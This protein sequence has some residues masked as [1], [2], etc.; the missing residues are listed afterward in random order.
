LDLCEIRPSE[1]A[2]QFEYLLAWIYD[3]NF[4]LPAASIINLALCLEIP[5]I[6]LFDIQGVGT[7]LYFRCRIGSSDGRFTISVPAE[8][9]LE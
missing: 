4:S 2:K 3:D 5:G 1:F 7:G 6:I 9:F 8:E